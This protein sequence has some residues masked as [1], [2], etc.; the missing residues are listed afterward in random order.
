ERTETVKIGSLARTVGVRPSAIR[1]YESV[2]VLPV[3]E[4]RG[5]QR[6]Y[7]PE[8]VERLRL[9]RAGQALGFTLAE[10]AVVLRGIGGARVSAEWRRIAAR[11]IAELDRAMAA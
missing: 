1:Y 2:G 11:K 4:R 9:L 3:T 5:A 6:V 10:M 7:G 8:A